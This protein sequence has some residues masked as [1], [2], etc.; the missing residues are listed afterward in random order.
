MQSENNK[1]LQLNKTYGSLVKKLRIERTNFSIN[2]LAQSYDI[3]RGNLSKIENGCNDTK[4]S[5]M[6]KISEAL[7][8]K[9]SEVARI[10]E[11]N[12][13]QDFTLID[14]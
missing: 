8:L 13:P 1:T 2:K 3:A 7:G 14:E 10:L 5:T 9:F 4:L 12:L 6:W 11:E